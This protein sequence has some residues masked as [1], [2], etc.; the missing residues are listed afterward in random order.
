MFEEFQGLENAIATR[1]DLHLLLQDPSSSDPAFTREVVFSANGT[2]NVRIGTPFR[3]S[4]RAFAAESEDVADAPE[5]VDVLPWTVTAME[6]SGDSTLGTIRVTNFAGRPTFGTVRQLQEGSP[7]PAKLSAEVCAE[8]AV[9]GLGSLHTVTPV[10]ISAEINSIPPFGVEAAH[11]NSGILVDNE[12]T[13]RGMIVGRSIT[14][15][16][17][18]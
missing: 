18:A 12:G 14:L 3:V 16:G 2:M 1:T 11:S 13:P 7:F 9:E 5:N 10:P 8:V 6:A 17:P 15:L 4:A